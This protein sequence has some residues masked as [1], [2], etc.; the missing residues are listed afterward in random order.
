MSNELAMTCCKALSQN[1]SGTTEEKHEMSYHTRS[2]G[3]DSNPGSI[4]YEREVLNTCVGF[5]VIT[6][7]VMK[8]TI[9]WDMT[10]CSPMK[11]G[12]K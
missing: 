6:A 11:A 10:P 3:T 12:G 9:F 2:S 7:V 1:L 4:E 8:S 5:E